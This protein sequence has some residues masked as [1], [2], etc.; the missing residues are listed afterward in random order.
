MIKLLIK[1]QFMEVFSFLF[2]DKKKG[3]R[4][5][6]LS[7]ALLVALYCLIF[8]SISVLVYK[9]AEYLCAPL[10]SVGFAWL[11]IALISLVSVAIGVL[12]SVFATYSSLYCASDNDLL[13]SMPI[14]PRKIIIARLSTVALTAL[15]YQFVVL[16]PATVVWFQNL[17]N[18]P[19]QVI[20][21]LLVL[22]F[23]VLFTTALSCLLGWG[24]A[25]AL[26]RV[27]RKNFVTVVASLLFIAVYYYLYFNAYSILQS[28]LKNPENIGSKVKSIFFYFYHLGLAADGKAI[29][30]LFVFLITA[31][32]VVLAVWLASRS[33]ISSVTIKKGTVKGKQ[34]LI[35][36]ERKLSSALFIKELKRFTGSA[37]YMLNCCLGT[38]FMPI[39]GVVLLFN[40]DFVDSILSQL[41]LSRDTAAMYACVMISF[42]V[43][44]NDITAPS[45]SLEG[46]NLWIYKTLPIKAIDIFA[47]KIKLHLA[48]TI[49]PAMFVSICAL[50]VLRPSAV[51]WALI[52]LAVLL[53]VL[54]T[55]LAGLW[56]NLR[57]PK[58]DWTNDVVPIKQSASVTIAM[59]GGWGTV[60]ALVVVYKLTASILSNAVFLALSSAIL[61]A[62]CIALI[63]WLKKRGAI[64]FAKL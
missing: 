25:I 3:K 41:I 34:K 33:L 18:G 63:C 28:I 46:K 48:L 43:C 16:I 29:S 19:I 12:G 44:M 14:P 32:L 42:M 10:V 1:K 24:V 36:K 40:G 2:R 62:L 64:I 31:I 27:K 35:C 51:M 49:P 58:L 54:L 23:I 60:I 38:L 50:A 45:I 55:A 4:R 5:S 61:G 52:P 22:F 8:A 7:M 30:L 39:I 47:A 57:V 59:F 15:M 17:K 26:I 37:N 6:A 53:F 9:G 21:T 20:F 56:L 11:Y 13:L